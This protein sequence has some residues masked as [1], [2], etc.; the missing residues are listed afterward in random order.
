MIS[1]QMYN[2]LNDYPI[3]ETVIFSVKTTYS[4]FP[5]HIEC[6]IDGDEMTNGPCS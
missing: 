6:P 1:L 4:W 2:L 3:Q 5:R